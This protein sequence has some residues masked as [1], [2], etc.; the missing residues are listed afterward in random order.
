MAH[1]RKQIRDAVLARL[2]TDLVSDFAD[3]IYGNRFRTLFPQNLPALLVY[4][5]ADPETA[6]ISVEAPREYKRTLRLSIE[7]VVKAD[8]SLD[9]AL[10]ALAEKVENSVFK[11]ETFGGTCADTIL[12]ETAMDLLSEGEKPIGGMKITLEMPYSQR[13]PADAG[14]DDLDD[15]NTGNVKIDLSQNGAQPDGT[16]ESEDTLD[17]SEEE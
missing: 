16:I 15:L 7:I 10:D 11:D 14:D 6:E 8:D 9:D 12:S 3:R 17:V 4:T 1:Q 13:L 2:R 5:A